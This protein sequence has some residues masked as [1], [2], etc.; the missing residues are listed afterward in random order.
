MLEL[1]ETGGARVIPVHRQIWLWPILSPWNPTSPA[2]SGCGSSG[3]Q[4]SLSLDTAKHQRGTWLSWQGAHSLLYPLEQDRGDVVLPEAAGVA[5]HL[6]ATHWLNRM[7]EKLAQVLGQGSERAQSAWQL[8]ERG[9]NKKAGWCRSFLGPESSY[10]GMGGPKE[11]LHGARVRLE[12]FKK[13]WCCP[14][15]PSHSWA[16]QVPMRLG[17]TFLIPGL[18]FFGSP[19]VCF[20]RRLQRS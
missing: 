1:I 20:K 3:L 8:L 12:R 11:Q 18:W 16:V 17:R 13:W 19:T 6:Q 9:L 7:R 10:L 4:D 14:I 15:P 5:L 2:P